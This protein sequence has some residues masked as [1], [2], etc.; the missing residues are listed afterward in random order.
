[1]MTTTTEAARPPEPRELGMTTMTSFE[2]LGLRDLVRDHWTALAIIVFGP[3]SVAATQEDVDR[4]VAAGILDPTAARRI[5]PIEDAYLLGFGRQRLEQAHASPV[6]DAGHIPGA[7]NA[8]FGDGTFDERVPSLDKAATYLIY[9]HADAPA[10]GAAQALVA[11]GFTSVYRLAGNFEAW[12]GAGYPVEAAM[13]EYT[14]L[15]PAEAKA[16]I[17]RHRGAIVIDVSPYWDAGH[18][19]GAL[20]YPLSDGS[21]DA[22]IPGLD[23]DERYLVYCHGD[24]PSIQGAQKLV[25]AGFKYV[26]RLE[27]NYGAWVAAGYPVETAS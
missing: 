21:L 5:D 17:E 9:C 18:L 12:S 1:M 20:A 10:I 3:E 26:Y 14:D 15:P 23:P 8:P 4:L 2:L 27:G 19:P 25:D 16:L 24:G 7:F 6:F 11:A 22:A 13:S